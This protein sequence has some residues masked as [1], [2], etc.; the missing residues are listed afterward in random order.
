MLKSIST[1]ETD[2][3]SVN[4]QEI[5][6]RSIMPQLIVTGMQIKI[7]TNSIFRKNKEHYREVKC[8]QGRYRYHLVIV[9]VCFWFNI[10]I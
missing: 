6:L 1:E 7:D 5:T 9:G 10:H 2:E 4:L 3:T 8:L